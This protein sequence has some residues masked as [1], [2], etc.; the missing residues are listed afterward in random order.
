M[1]KK[2][3][4]LAAAIVMIVVLTMVFVASDHYYRQN[5][6]LLVDAL[7]KVRSEPEAGL[8]LCD[9][10]SIEEYARDC[11]RAYLSA[12]LE[13]ISSKNHVAENASEKQRTGS[14]IRILNEATERIDAVCSRKVMKDTSD[15]SNLRSVIELKKNAVIRNGS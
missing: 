11:Y 6:E 7:Q 14:A 9:R 2:R 8:E 5:A 4:V 13:R 15:C 12:E 10:I 1:H 3:G